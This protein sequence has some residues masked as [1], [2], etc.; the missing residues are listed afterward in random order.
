MTLDT[1]LNFGLRVLLPFAIA[2]G[3]FLALT[4]Y[5]E[6][7]YETSNLDIFWKKLLKWALIIGIA[8]L[9]ISVIIHSQPYI[10]TKQWL[11]NV[12]HA[13]ERMPIFGVAVTSIANFNHWLA[14]LWHNWSDVY[15]SWFEIVYLFGTIIEIFALK[16][17]ITFWRAFNVIWPAAVKFPLILT[18]FTGRQ[19]PIGDI[20]QAGLLKAKV[21]ENLP[22]SYEDAV[23]GYDEQGRPFQDGAGG[24]TQTMQKKMVAQAMKRTT[25]AVRTTADGQ[26]TARILI[27]QS[28]ET[29]TDRA[30]ENTL[31]GFGERV[32]GDS[33]YFPSDPTYSTELRGYVFDSSVAYDAGDELGSY[34]AIFSDPLAED[35]KVRNGGD[36]MFKVLWGD[37][38]E[39][40][41]YLAHLTPYAIYR[42]AVKKASDKYFVD[43]SA[44]KAK[45]KVQQ[46]LDLSVV[47]EPTDPDT[48]NNIGEQR[49]L[50][51]QTAKARV[52]DVTT[53]LN[54]FGLYGQ[55][56]GVKVGGNTAI[57]EYTLPPDTK[58]PND[59]D[60]VQQQIANLLRIESIPVITLRAG[61]LSVSMENGVS[62]PIS[63]TDMIKKRKKGASTIISGLIGVDAL[64]NDIYFELG[65]KNP[66][67]MFFGKTGTGKTVSIMT[68]LYSVMS[69]TD[70]KHLRIA[71]ADGKGNSFEFMKADGDHPNPYTYA[72]IGD[73]SQDINYTRALVMAMEKE[74]R[75]RIDLFK[76]AAV[77]KLAD[78]NKLLAK[79]GKDPL[80][81]ILFVV[82]EFSAITQQDRQLKASESNKFGTIDR[83]EY[84][85]KMSRSV[86]I[87][88]LLAN[89]SARKELVPG[90]ISANVTGRISLGVSEPVEAE[91]ALPETGIKVN[92]ISQ[93]G[94]FYSILNGPNHPEHGNGPYLPDEVM[95]ALNDKLTEK[96]GKCKYVMN[97]EEVFAS[98]GI[99]DK[100]DGSDGDQG[101][102]ESSTA[103]PDSLAKALRANRE[104]R[105]EARQH[106]TPMLSKKTPELAEIVEPKGVDL[107]RFMQH[108][109]EFVNWMEADHDPASDAWW[110]T[111][112]NRYLNENP[113]FKRL[114][115]ATQQ[116]LQRTA[117]QKT[118]AVQLKLK[119]GNRRLPRI[120]QKPANENPHAGTQ[121]VGIISALHG[122]D[123]PPI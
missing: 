17:R 80:P 15:I 27:K 38:K 120:E 69:A 12:V 73:G 48:G 3:S 100:T 50:A 78:Y 94:E 20:I 32:S 82:D 4:A 41:S 95:W 112:A 109:E 7:R 110:V 21:R 30:I 118:G 84:I 101:S 56:K 36:G 75:R 87:R 106:R 51:L 43:T 89:Q 70:P 13:I 46:N 47:P 85:A 119:R 111:N 31:K 77:S 76:K 74:T 86:G 107:E 26:R 96:F 61:V 62:I 68:I 93:P 35:A 102:T 67:S 19:T 6:H 99:E 65:D 29:Q 72:P 113:N 42:Q 90:K 53:A 2:S 98:A 14:T 103:T 108:P 8:L 16:W 92:L 116:R 37:V 122:N 88:M 121:K 81:E 104:H 28:R 63:F 9:I 64:G 11:I 49:Q 39:T 25:V 10:A 52:K 57:Y 79:Q 44:D 58:L 1:L 117:A 66:H 114:D 24:T 5:L 105:L 33:I 71:Y 34:T 91:I 123:Q 55:L 40:V 45:Y 18:Y 97:R 23:Q 115:M 83:F 22:D 60:K 54:G 59:F